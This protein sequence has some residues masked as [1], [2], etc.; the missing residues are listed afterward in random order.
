MTLNAP[1]APVYALI[2]PSGEFR[3]QFEGGQG[4]ATWFLLSG[5]VGAS[6]ANTIAGQGTVRA[7]SWAAAESAE[8]LTVFPFSLAGTANGA[9]YDLEITVGAVGDTELVPAHIAPDTP[10]AAGPVTLAD[11]VGTY[12]ATGAFSSSGSLLTL[13]LAVDPADPSQLRIT[14]SDGFG[15]YGNPVAGT[16]TPAALGS[17]P[18]M[19]NFSVTYTPT[20]DPVLPGF[21]FGPSTV[22][23]LAYLRQAPA[24]NQLVVM[25]DNNAEPFTAVLTVQP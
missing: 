16:V 25:G 21:Q 13:T 4:P 14:G 10:F 2:L 15:G 9:G 18:N 24:G 23:G 22:N 11:L 6:G 8:K 12:T 3:M 5:Q 17:H 1:S 20:A 19:F 7:P